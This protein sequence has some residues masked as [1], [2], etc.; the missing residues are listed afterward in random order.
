MTV[1]TVL[2]DADGVTQWNREFR[3]RMR[4]LLGEAVTIDELMQRELDALTGQVDFDAELTGVLAE[5]GTGVSLEELYTVWFDTHPDPDVLALVDRVRAGGV[6]VYL[7]TN[8]QPARGRHM[9]RTLGYERHLDGQFYSFEVG[10]A[11]PDPR[12]FTAITNRLG[13]TPAEVLFIDDM[14]ANVAGARSAGLLAEHLPH[15]AGAA[16]LA[17]LLSSHGVPTDP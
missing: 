3:P 12:F 2:L 5:R 9:Q 10:L 17:D 11:K 15:G 8:Q 1:T 16:G 14:P 7:A 6:P 13:V 4:A